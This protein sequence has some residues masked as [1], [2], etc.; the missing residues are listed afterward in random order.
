MRSAVLRLPS[1]MTVL[2]NLLTSALLYSGSGSSSRFGISRLRGISQFLRLRA[3]GAVLRTT[4]LAAL[5]AHR[6]ERAAHHVVTHAGQV[7]HTAATDEHE[8]VLLEVVA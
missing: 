3:L 2:M 6:V 5:D 1:L 7:L 4:L 8:R